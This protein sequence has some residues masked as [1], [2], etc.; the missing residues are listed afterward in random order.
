M[1]KR[2]PAAKHFPARYCGRLV[3]FTICDHERQARMIGGQPN[4]FCANCGARDPI[5]GW[6]LLGKYRF[7][8]RPG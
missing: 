4:Y 3:G 1:P 8:G 6:V 7:I 5:E 2:E